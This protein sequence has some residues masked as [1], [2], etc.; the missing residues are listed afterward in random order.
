MYEVYEGDHNQL[1]CGYIRM[2][3]NLWYPKY[4]IKHFGSAKKV[5]Q[6]I[7]EERNTVE[8]WPTDCYIKIIKAL[9]HT[10][11]KGSII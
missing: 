8:V 9:P 2:T 11:N 7:T 6:A 1:V 4:L 3:K 5:K 10:L